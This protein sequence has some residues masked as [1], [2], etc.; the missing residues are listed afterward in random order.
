MLKIAKSGAMDWMLREGPGNYRIERRPLTPE[1]H[2]CNLGCSRYRLE[3]GKKSCP[4]HYHYGND[5]A[6]YVLSGEL[7]LLFDGQP[8]TL[9][10]GDYV[11][12]PRGTGDAHQLENRSLTPVEYL[13]FSTMEPADVIMYPNSGKIGVF[14]GG[15]PGGAE[16]EVSVRQWVK[17]DAIDYWAGEED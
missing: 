3:P 1:T 4:A 9:T 7:T 17:D 5:E 15:A 2:A 10:E 13:C 16:S 11:T 6:I 8:H 14:G 12:L